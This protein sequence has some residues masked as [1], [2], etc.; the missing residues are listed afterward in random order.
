MK[1]AISIA[2]VLVMVFAL[3]A[4][5]G[6]KSS[7][8]ASSAP[9][10]SSSSAAAPAPAKA[11]PVVLRFSYSLP[12]GSPCDQA[13]QAMAAAVAEKTDGRITI[14]TYP[15]CGLSGGD[16]VKAFEMLVSGDIDIHGSSPFTAGNFDGRYFVMWLPWLFNDR[17]A[18]E[19]ALDG[20]LSDL[21]NTWA[22]E[23]GMTILTTCYAG[24]R[25]LSNSVR[26]VKTV[27]DIKGL[28][29]RVPGASMFIDTFNALGAAPVAMDFSEVYTASQQGT[30][31][32]QE[33][34]LSTYYSAALQEV[35]K[36]I[37]MYNMVYDTTIF[38]MNSAKFNS[39]S[40]ED[41]QI[42]LECAKEAGIQYRDNVIA[43]DEA[44]ASS[45]VDEYGCTV[46]YLTDEELKTFQDAVTPIY[47]QYKSV[48]GED[49]VTEVLKL[50]GKG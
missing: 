31:D 11:D 38:Y 42:L 9:A 45:L 19:S 26:E 23:K 5:G 33:N 49:V 46:T 13:A 30:I 8:S 21:L 48:I 36:Y 1:R 7:Q 14:E 24:A 2:L 15:N 35:Q 25:E 44:L 47:E 29:I 41:Q 4:C 37:T 18:L 50:A 28:V 22:K 20:G 16:L 10:S 34:P 12:S 27:D 3:A 39:L 6:G 17:E 40:A 43:T 32:G